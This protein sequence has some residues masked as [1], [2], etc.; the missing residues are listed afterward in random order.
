MGKTAA[1]LLL[2]A[3]AVSAAYLGAVVWLLSVWMVDDTR[4]F[5]MQP[6]DWY[7]EGGRRLGVALLIG[8]AFG[9]VVHLVNRRWVVPRL[10]TWRHLLTWTAP[11]LGCCV[12]TSGAVGV[13][14]FVVTRPF[15]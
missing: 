5:Q 9:G 15:M 2:V 4:A 12:A 10:P 3:E 11:A 13:V 14:Q 8:V 1:V 6:V 7:V